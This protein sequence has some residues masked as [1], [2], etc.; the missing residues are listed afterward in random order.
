MVA[1]AVTSLRLGIT[2][3]TVPTTR[4]RVLLIEPDADNRELYIRGL[5]MA[6]GFDLVAAEDATSATIA[7]GADAPAIV[8][9][10]TRRPG[11][12]TVALLRHLSE[13]GVPVIALTTAP[14][15][16]HEALRVAGARLVLLKPYLPDQLAAVITQV[17]G[18]PLP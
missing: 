15:S 12:C 13:A 4:V 18:G 17:L 7:M 10:A 3:K 5:M 8:V 9:A 6:A 2:R 11:P 1:V 14:L 16:E